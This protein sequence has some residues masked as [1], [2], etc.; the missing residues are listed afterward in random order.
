MCLKFARLARL[1]ERLCRRASGDR[2][3]AVLVGRWPGPV[4]GV[5]WARVR[6]LLG[7]VE[8]L[9]MVRVEVGVWV[10]RWML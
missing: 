8:G 10:R 3:R 7:G 1:G 5:L 2:P 9:L 4:I 6:M